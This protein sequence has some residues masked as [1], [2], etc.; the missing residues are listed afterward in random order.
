VS[1]ARYE[2]RKV[3]VFDRELGVHVRPTDPGWSAY[4]R[5]MRE[6]NIPAPIPVSER[7]SLGTRRREVAARVNGK[8]SA[9]LGKLV[10]EGP[11][12]HRF[13]ADDTSFA[14]LVAA[15]LVLAMGEM[16]PPGFAWRSTDNVMVPLKPADARALLRDMVRKR[17]AV[18]ERSWALKDVAVAGSENPEAVDLEAGWP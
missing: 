3:G 17:Q 6:G 7:P 5:W 13:A 11:D 14:N 15:G 2:L 1:A 4:E 18:F 10:V 9:I 12:G 8:R 16:L